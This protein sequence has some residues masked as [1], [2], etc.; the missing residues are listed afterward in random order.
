MDDSASAEQL[1]AAVQQLI[2]S[3]GLLHVRKTPCG[4]PLSVSQAHCLM[5][6]RDQPVGARAPNQRRLAQY[7]GLDKSTVTRLLRQL[8]DRDLVRVEA[9][10][11]DGRARCVSLTERGHRIA[12]ATSATSLEFFRQILNQLEPD[13]RDGVVRA[14]QGLTRAIHCLRD[15]EP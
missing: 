12:G 8:R 3:M 15:E 1:R 4:Q 10:P 11:Q 13:D 6:L 9:S 5:F 14:V 7:L 2:R